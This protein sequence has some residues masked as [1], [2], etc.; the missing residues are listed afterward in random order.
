VQGVLSVDISDWNTNGHNHKTARQC[1]PEQIKDEVLLQITTA[2]NDDD[3][4]ELVDAQLRHW[5]LDESIHFPNPNLMS[6]A[7][8]LLINTAGSW[9]H[10]PEAVTKIRNFFLAGDYVRTHTDLATM[11]AA[12]E[13]ARRAVNG[14]LK[15][16]GSRKRCKVWPLSEPRIFAPFRRYDRWRFHRGLPHNELT[17][18]LALW[19]AVPIW[20]LLRLVFTL[21]YKLVDW[22]IAPVYRWL[23]Q[24]VASRRSS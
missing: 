16:S 22:L 6:N 19:L 12:N 2:L 13:S 18:R 3:K 15:A 4:N 20:L 10:R 14:I 5:F 9:Q 8:P 7:E 23:R 1:T 21:Y 24:I 11:E 17:I